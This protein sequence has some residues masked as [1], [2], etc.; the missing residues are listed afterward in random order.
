M[1]LSLNSSNL[2]QEDNYGDYAH[3][4][5]DLLTLS[6]DNEARPRKVA[7]IRN[8]S[9]TVQRREVLPPVTTFSSST[10][11]YRSSQTGPDLECPNCPPEPQVHCSELLLTEDDPLI[12]NYDT[13]AQSPQLE[14]INFDQL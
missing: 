12:S 11:M 8:Q 9:L 13:S 3:L 10:D 5:R 6:D 2:P 1:N 14:R 7:N 4:I